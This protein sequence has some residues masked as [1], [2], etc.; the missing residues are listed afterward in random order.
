MVGAEYLVVDGGTEELGLQTVGDEEIV[1]APPCVL[2][3]G[4][5]TVGPPG[6]D[7]LPVGIEVTERIGEARRQQ[8]A[9]LAALLVRESG[10]AAVGLGILQVDLAPAVFT[11][12]PGVIPVIVPIQTP[13]KHAITNSNIAIN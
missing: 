2:L 9:E 7:V 12:I 3:A 10:V 4:L 11:C 5:E 8:F 6:V 13:N 1:D